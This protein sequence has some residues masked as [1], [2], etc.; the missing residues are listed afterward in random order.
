VPVPD[1]PDPLGKRALFWAPAERHEHGPRNPDED[2]VPGKR[3]LFSDAGSASAPSAGR[4]RIRPSETDP[5]PV[6][7]VSSRRRALA[8]GGSREARRAAE[9]DHLERP[10]GSGMF[11]TLR[12]QCSSCRVQS[13]VDLVEFIVLHLPLWLWRP[14]RG[15][16]RFMTCPACR[17]R[18]WMS[19]SWRR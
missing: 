4:A 12:L 16:T 18:T 13:Q 11:G 8:D 6:D 1:A 14:G 17:R 7:H 3:A 15:Y 2:A 10:S 9:A 19:A 5:G